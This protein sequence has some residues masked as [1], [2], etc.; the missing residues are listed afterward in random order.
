MKTFLKKGHVLGLVKLVFAA[1]T[2]ADKRVTIY[3]RCSGNGLRDCPLQC[4]NITLCPEQPDGYRTLGC[5]NKP[6]IPVFGPFS[7]KGSTLQDKTMGAPHNRVAAY[8]QC[9][10]QRL[11]RT[12]ATDR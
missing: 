1:R 3:Y 5:G 2:K 10:M 7:C 9:V 12:Y 6:D 11:P 8:Q 4:Y